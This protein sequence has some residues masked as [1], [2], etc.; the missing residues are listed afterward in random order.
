MLRNNSTLKVYAYT[1]YDHI[2]VLYYHL[3][4]VQSLHSVRMVSQFPAEDENKL[5]ELASFSGT[6]MSPL[7]N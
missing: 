4:V 3:D 2:Q 6:C 5:Q 7:F 1:P